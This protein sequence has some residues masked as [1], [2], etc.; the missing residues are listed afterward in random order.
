MLNV[1]FFCAI[2]KESVSSKNIQHIQHF[3]RKK[4]IFEK[5][6]QNIFNIFNILAETAIFL[7]FVSEKAL[8]L[9]F[10]SIFYLKVPGAAEPVLFFVNDKKGP[11]K[12]GANLH[13]IF[14]GIF[15]YKTGLKMKFLAFFRPEFE[16]AAIYIYIYIYML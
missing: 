12:F 4:H 11:K 13:Q 5:Q 6:P 8:F 7:F 16:G 1:V 9:Q 10:R 2:P 14:L 3:P 15:Y